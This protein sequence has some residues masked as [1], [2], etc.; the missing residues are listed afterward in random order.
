MYYL[1]GSKHQTRSSNW[2][3]N[4]TWEPCR[5]SWKVK[6]LSVKK[7]LPKAQRFFW[8]NIES[9]YFMKAET[10]SNGC[11]SSF[12]LSTLTFQCLLLCSSQNRLNL[13]VF[14]SREKLRQSDQSGQHT[15]EM[16]TI[17]LLFSCRLNLWPSSLYYQQG[18]SPEAPGEVSSRWT[19]WTSEGNIHR[20][21]DR[22]KDW[23]ER[24]CR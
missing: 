6:Q 1:Y 5:P 7:N 15:W 4:F 24:I 2:W 20:W 23:S 3:V 14:V 13:Y 17:Y 19:S 16:V 11:E 18:F 8:W 9:L 12:H 22:Q 21:D 10:C